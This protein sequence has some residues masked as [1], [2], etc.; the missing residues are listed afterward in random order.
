MSRYYI[1]TLGPTDWRRLLAN[2]TTQ[3]RRTKS[4][5]EMA[6]CWE[7]AR[8]LNRG[9]PPEIAS[10]VD[11]ISHLA[12]ASLIFGVPEHQVHFEGG[13]HPSQS[14]LWGLLGVSSGLVSFTIEAKAGEKLDDIVEVWLGKKATDRT[15]KPER[16]VALKRHL[17]IPG[18]DVSRIRYQLLHRT[19][20]A[21]KEAERCKAQFALMIVQSF[22]RVADEQSWEDFCAFAE[23]M[24][25]TAAEGS[26]AASARKTNVPLLLGW[27]TCKPATPE[28]CAAAV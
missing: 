15:N 18:E 16:L 5:F 14:D 17:G 12:G 28:L 2:P 19:A 3:W 11:S 27:V 7:A 25:S 22:N 4:A 8:D 24:N 23:L 26:I 20:S 9:L 1:P 6:V 13:G 10:A 21:L